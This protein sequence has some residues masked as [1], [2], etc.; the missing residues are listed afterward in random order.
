M[1]RNIINLVIAI[2]CLINFLISLNITNIS[3][4]PEYIDTDYYM[5]SLFNEWAIIILLIIMILFNLFYLIKDKVNKKK[6]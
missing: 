5:N 2:S 3:R 4:S 6:I 1:K